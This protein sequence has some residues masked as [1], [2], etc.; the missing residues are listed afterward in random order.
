MQYPGPFGR[1]EDLALGQGVIIAARWLLVAAGLVLAL[2]A[3]PSAAT[4]RTQ[5]VLILVLAVCNFALQGQLLRRRRTLA[6]VAYAASAA[7]I[8]IVTALVVAD[9]GYGSGLYVFYFPAVLALS[10]AFPLTLTI[11]YV[12]AVLAATLGVALYTMPAGAEPN[13]LI[14]CLMVAAVALCG[15]VYADIERRRRHRV[16]ETEEEVPHAAAG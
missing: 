11:G 16:I 9:G 3:P 8:A 14:R 4:L 7:D 13:V 6:A 1:D 12:A 15:V 5:V 2:I 10:V